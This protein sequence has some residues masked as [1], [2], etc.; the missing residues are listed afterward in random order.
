MRIFNDASFSTAPVLAR[1]TI[2][3]NIRI[4]PLDGQPFALG[5]RGALRSHIQ[6]CGAWGIQSPFV[7]V[8]PIV[9]G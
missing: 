6:E 7:I 4:M 1:E 9:L 3:N 2:S 8:G 5:N